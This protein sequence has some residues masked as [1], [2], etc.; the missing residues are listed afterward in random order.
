MVTNSVVLLQ[1]LTSFPIYS[2]SVRLLVSF[3]SSQP[4]GR[5]SIAVLQAFLEHRRVPLVIWD[6]PRD[7]DDGFRKQAAEVMV[8]RAQTPHD[9]KSWIRIAQEWMSLVRDPEQNR[10]RR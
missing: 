9:R 10:P 5:R 3:A 6:E 8:D 1:P 7:D 4:N 2:P